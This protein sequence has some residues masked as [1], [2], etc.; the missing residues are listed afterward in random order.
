MS[1]GGTGLIK[2]AIRR[3]VYCGQNVDIVSGFDLDRAE[4]AA[5][6]FKYVRVRKPIFVIGDPPR[7]D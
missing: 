6:L 3:G 7:S 4:D 5:A 1:G 2:L